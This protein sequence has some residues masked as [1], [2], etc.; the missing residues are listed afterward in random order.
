LRATRCNTLQHA[1]TRC[2]G[3]APRERLRV[4]LRF[5]PVSLGKGRS[6]CQRKSRKRLGDRRKNAPSDT[7][8]GAKRFREKARKDPDQ[9]GT[10]GAKRSFDPHLIFSG[11][12]SHLLTLRRRPV[13]SAERAALRSAGRS[14]CGPSN[15][16]EYIIGYTKVKAWKC[17]AVK[18]ADA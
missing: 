2:N 15:L 18:L 16:I 5:T 4:Q 14:R 7:R 9:I 8:K 17:R 6:F 10:F 12:L 11:R 13:P 1:A 3:V